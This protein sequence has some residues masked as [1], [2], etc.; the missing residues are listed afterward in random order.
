MRIFTFCIWWV[1]QLERKRGY[2][3]KK[4]H[5]PIGIIH[6]EGNYLLYNNFA[7]KSFVLTV[8]RIPYIVVD[9]WMHERN[10]KYSGLYILCLNEYVRTKAISIVEFAFKT[11]ET[12]QKNVVYRTNCIW[13]RT[14]WNILLF[15]YTI[16]TKPDVSVW[17]TDDD[18]SSSYFIAL[19]YDVVL[20]KLQVV[21]EDYSCYLLCASFEWTLPFPG[22][23]VASFCFWLC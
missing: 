11:N 8:N 22:N 12:E 17:C 16:P 2:S 7:M 14:I 13:C 19:F 10:D 23:S 6:R 21:H 3:Q 5:T 18:E 9:T 20:H 4:C 1:V 15:K